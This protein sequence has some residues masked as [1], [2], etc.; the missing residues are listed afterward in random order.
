MLRVLPDSGADEKAVAVCHNVLTAGTVIDGDHAFG[1]LLEKMVDGGGGIVIKA[2]EALRDLGNNIRVIRDVG[3]ALLRV[4]GIVN[5]VVLLHDKAD[6]ALTQLVI[7]QR[8]CAAQP[9][10][11]LLVSTGQ[12]HDA[13]VGVAI[14]HIV[15]DIVE[16]LLL[17]PDINAVSVVA[18]FDFGPQAGDGI[19]EKI[20]AHGGNTEIFLPEAAL[21][22]KV[23]HKV[24]LD[25]KSVV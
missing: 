2:A 9:L 3:E 15:H 10:H 25:R 12:E 22:I 4:G 6:V 21:F 17:Q 19:A 20:G 14:L 5:G 1:R 18:L 23:L 16:G 8:L 7:F 11:P 13:K 24:H